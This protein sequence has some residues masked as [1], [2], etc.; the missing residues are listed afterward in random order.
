M[1]ALRDFTYLD[2]MY[3]VS[4]NVTIILYVFF[5][6]AVMLFMADIFISLVI[7]V[8]NKIATKY[9]SG[10]QRRGEEILKKEHWTIEVLRCCRQSKNS[11][12]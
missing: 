3:E 2:R 9:E 8:Y 7:I 5:I 10:K 1:I 11:C 12:V 4:P 6:L